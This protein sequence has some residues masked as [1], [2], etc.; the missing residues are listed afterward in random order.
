MRFPVYYSLRFARR[1]ERHTQSST[2]SPSLSLF[3]TPSLL[4]VFF[5]FFCFPARRRSDCK[6]RE[7]KYANCRRSFYSSC[8]LMLLIMYFVASHCD[9]DSFTN[10]RLLIGVTLA[11]ARRVFPGGVFSHIISVRFSHAVLL[12][13]LLT[14]VLV[15]FIHPLSVQ[16]FFS[17]TLDQVIVG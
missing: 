11:I 2:N 5:S 6:A 14:C 7:S 13:L 9:Q 12:L 16:V 10:A 8:F 3:F 15:T 17:L 1:L 4:Y